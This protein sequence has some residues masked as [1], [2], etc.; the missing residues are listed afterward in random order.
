MRSDVLRPAAHVLVFAAAAL[1]MGI[2]HASAADLDEGF[3]PP[4]PRPVFEERVYRRPVVV[5]Q[6]VVVE[7]R[8]VVERPVIVPRP[9]YRP[10]YRPYGYYRPYHRLYGPRFAYGPRPWGWYR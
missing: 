9:Y 6:P 8:V 10:F 7:R 3:D 2:A 5:E 4:P 1:T